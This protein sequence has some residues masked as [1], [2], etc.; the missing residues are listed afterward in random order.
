MHP[1]AERQRAVAIH[2]GEIAVDMNMRRA[3]KLHAHF[4]AAT[5]FVAP[6]DQR[7]VRLPVAK[8]GFRAVWAAALWKARKPCAAFDALA[9]REMPAVA[10]HRANRRCAGIDG[11]DAADFVHERL[12]HVQDAAIAVLGIEHCRPA[13]FAPSGGVAPI[14]R[15]RLP[16]GADDR[17]DA[18]PNA[19][20]AL[21][22]VPLFDLISQRGPA[23][24][25]EANILAML[26]C[27]AEIERLSIERTSSGKF[28]SRT[29]AGK[30]TPSGPVKM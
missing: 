2:V 19:G 8:P 11:R 27:L 22:G 15:D 9:A 28:D 6:A 14:H 16:R 23:G 18:N 3:A 13:R 26:L 17:R 7:R 24:V 25:G 1:L 5:P 30:A 29:A 4:A 21:V 12:V 10:D 20:R